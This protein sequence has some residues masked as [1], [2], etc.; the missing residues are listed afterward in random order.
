MD[1]NDRHAIED[2]FVRL[3][4]AE[5]RLP[6]RDPEAEALIR[7]EIGRHPAAPYYMAQTIVV[8]QQALEESRRRIEA[9]EERGSGL[10]S[11]VPRDDRRSAQRRSQRDDGGPWDN[12]GGGF[13]AGA[14]QTAV[15]VA[16]GVLLGNMLAGALFGGGDANAEE[17]RPEETDASDAGGDFDG[18]DFGDF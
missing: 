9:L 3:A 8:Q 12:R 5:R 2:L 18:G 4:E 7:S 1:A 11:G 17:I 15:G 10:F 16:G 6:Q 14:A 13:L